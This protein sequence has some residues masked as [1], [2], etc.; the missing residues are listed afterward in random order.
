[1]KLLPKQYSFV[2]LALVAAMQVSVAA[3]TI[4]AKISGKGGNGKCT[5]EV[6]VDGV[7][8]VQI[9]YNQGYL[10]TKAGQ[11][12]TWR[13]LDCNQ[14]LPRNPNS[15]RFKGVDGRGKQYLLKDPNSNNGVAVIRIEDPK[16]GREGYTGD[17]MWNGGNNGGGQWG[18]GSGGWWNDNWNGGGGW[19]G[20]GGWNGGGGA[21]WSKNIVPNCQKAI[22]NQLVPQYGGS[23]TFQGQPSQNQGGS[24]V[25]VQGRA[26]YRDGRGQTGQIQYNCTMHPNGN[27]A[28]ATYNVVGGNFQPGPQPR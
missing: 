23:L 12:A 16:S 25:L 10:Q 3:Q 8:D 7:A 6:V 26:N 24:F 15:F 4:N 9:R 13:R 22:R 5:F 21:N 14:P 20:N 18:G 11:P 28:E 2:L 19:N 27:V 1:V 17:I